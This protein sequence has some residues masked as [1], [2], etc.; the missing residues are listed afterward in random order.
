MKRFL[1]YFFGT[2]LDRV[3]IGRCSSNFYHRRNQIQNG[4][5]DP[6][7]LLGI[8]QGNDA[9]EVNTLETELH[10]R[11]KEF[12]TSGEWFKLV[13]E[14]SAFI[15]DFAE[16]GED[17]LDEDHR[18]HRA[19]HNERY[20]NDP[21]YRERRRE[22][23]RNKEKRREYRQRPEVKEKRREYS[24]RP[25]VKEKQRKYHQRPEVIVNSRNK[26]TYF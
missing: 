20:R 17:I 3:K 24:Q 26:L 5:P 7:K 15:E 16:P 11:F 2:D 13:P 8:I 21:E 25:E 18:L 10:Q 23:N 12:Q 14:I 4:C 1:V 19:H 22:S 9:S 6:I